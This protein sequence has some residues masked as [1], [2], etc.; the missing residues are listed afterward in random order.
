MEKKSLIYY[1]LAF[2]KIDFVAWKG[3]RGE[4]IV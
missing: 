3:R 1:A 2:W 4:I